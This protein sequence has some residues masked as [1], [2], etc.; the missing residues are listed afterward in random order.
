MPT[1][2]MSASSRRFWPWG[3][4]PES[5][6]MATLTPASM[7]RRTAARWMSMTSVALRTLAAGMAAPAATASRTPCGATSVGTS[8]VPRSSI[9]SMASSSR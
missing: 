2:T 5:V 1:S 8:Q 7:A 9:I 6:P 3:V 4:T